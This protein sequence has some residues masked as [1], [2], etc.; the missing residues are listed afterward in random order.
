MRAYSGQSFKSAK[1]SR[2]W[3]F[4]VYLT[5]GFVGGFVAATTWSVRQPVELVINTPHEA[6]APTVSSAD[7][8]LAA[9]EAWSDTS[10]ISVRTP[11]PNT[12]VKSPLVVEGLGRAFEQNAV[13]RL[14]DGKGVEITKIAVTGTAP[15]AG[16]Y[17]PYRAELT[18][19]KPKTKTGTLEIFQ[20]SPK[21]GKEIDKVTVPVRFE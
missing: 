21:D 10:N 9:P 1:R 3:R 4:L 15:D 13:V 19:E 18:F 5:V 7:E 11:Q 14:K 8:V 12:F 20:N 6:V 17:G 2:P 16:I